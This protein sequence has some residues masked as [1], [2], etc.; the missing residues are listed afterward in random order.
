[1]TKCTSCRVRRLEC[2]QSL[3][4]SECENA[5]R[6]CIRGYNIRFRHLAFD[7]ISKNATRTDYSKH[8]F[9]FDEQQTWVATNERVEFIPENDH[10]SSDS[11]AGE[12]TG[13]IFKGVVSDGEAQHAV[14]TPQQTTT[15]TPVASNADSPDYLT[16]FEERFKKTPSMGRPQKES[17]PMAYSLVD[18][19]LSEETLGPDSRVSYPQTPSVTT[20]LA[21]PLRNL[22]EGRLLQHFVTFLAPWVCINIL[23]ALCILADSIQSLTLAIVRGT[24]AKSQPAWQPLALS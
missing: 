17:V 6:E 13:N 23:P 3:T 19:S 9:F 20:E 8:E 5:G 12:T 21:L 11:P 14:I 4:C 2:N 22:Q 1:M 18:E 15:K 10:F 7:G 16:P 24:L